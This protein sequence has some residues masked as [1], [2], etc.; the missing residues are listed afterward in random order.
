VNAEAVQRIHRHPDDVFD[1]LS[2]GANNPSW[3]SGVVE[4]IGDEADVHVGTTYRQR[5]RHPLGFTVAT[6]YRVTALERPSRISFAVIGGGPVRPRGTFEID[7]VGGDATEVRYRLE[8]D[9]RG[10]TK[11]AAPWLV[12]AWLSFRRHVASLRNAKRI[13][14]QPTGTSDKAEAGNHLA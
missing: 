4:T 11:L 3:Q 8:Y 6:D 5:A 9:A 12:I 13:L 10:R 7:P 2:D 1:F 14:E